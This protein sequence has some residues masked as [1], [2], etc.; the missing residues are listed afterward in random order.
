[1]SQDPE[2]AQRHNEH[3]TTTSAATQ[4]AANSGPSLDDLQSKE[5]I[6]TAF[7]PDINREGVPGKDD[8]RM[9]EAYA[10]EFGR[11]QGLGN[12]ER[13]DWEMERDLNRARAILAKQ[14]YARPSGLGSRCNQSLRAAWTDVE[15][16][17][18]MLTDELAREI[19][20]TFE[21]NSMFKSLSIDARGFRGLTEVTAVSK[22][23]GFAGGSSSD[24][25]LLSKV[26]G[27]L[28]GG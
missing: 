2:Q 17:L 23:E 20:A 3:S 4:K 22:S 18:P 11:H 7:T 16:P 25:G 13:E 8:L 24:G 6:E 1:M 19:T 15:E 26:T 12:I 5:F 28:F 14:E 9:E 10:A 27:G 21:E